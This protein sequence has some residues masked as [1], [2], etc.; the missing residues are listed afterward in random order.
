[1]SLVFGFLA[2]NSSEA[3][4][5]ILDFHTPREMST[6]GLKVRYSKLVDFLCILKC[7]VDM[8]STCFGK[9]VVRVFLTWYV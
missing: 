3:C 5:Y 9:L 6:K 2:G 1:M 4:F 7:A 8:N